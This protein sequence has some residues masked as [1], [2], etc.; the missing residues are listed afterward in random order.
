MMFTT[1][2]QIQHALP[3]AAWHNAMIKP[4]P[5]LPQP[6]TFLAQHRKL[7][8]RAV[9]AAAAAASAAPAATA[10]AAAADGIVC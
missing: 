7:H 9:P 2:L 3:V 1:V 8:T 5:Q 4:L 10:A 6:N